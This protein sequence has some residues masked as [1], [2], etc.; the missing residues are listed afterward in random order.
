MIWH[1]LGGTDLDEDGSEKM[2][3]CFDLSKEEIDHLS[4]KEIDMFE[5]ARGN[6]D[7]NKI[8]EINT[9]LN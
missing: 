4:K 9:K 6:G 8:V 5:E 3:W 1:G 2:R 7:W